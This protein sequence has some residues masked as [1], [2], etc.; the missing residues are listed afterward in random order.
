LRE[1]GL[2]SSDPLIL[3]IDAAGSACAAAVAKGEQLLAIRYAAMMHGQAETLLPMIDG[4]MHEAGLKPAVLD[5]VAVTTGPGSFTGIRV[6]IAAARGI[7]LAAGLPLIGVGSFEAVAE[8]VPT[9]VIA[10][11]SLLVALEARRADLYLQFFDAA[12]RPLC[13]PAAILPEALAETVAKVEPRCR[14]IAGDAAARAAAVLG[15][16]SGPAVVEWAPSVKGALCAALRRWSA[17][18][19]G[20]EVRPLYLRPPDVTA[21]GG[22]REPRVS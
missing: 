6:G 15:L 16:G 21:A 8:L 10:G 19:R 20:S 18:E 17:G 14:A 9:A 12:R 3:A 13:Q 5:L 11:G 22:R 2:A 4:A 1:I 7:A